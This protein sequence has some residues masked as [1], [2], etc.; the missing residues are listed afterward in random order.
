MNKNESLPLKDLSGTK[1]APG[2]NNLTANTGNPGDSFFRQT[3][4]NLLEGCQILGF[5]WKYIYLNKSAEVHNRRPNAE[6]LGRKYTDMWPGIESSKVFSEIKRCLDDRE[7]IRM[8]NK[9]VYPDQKEGWFNL[10]LQPVPEGALILSYD[11]TRRKT[12]EMQVVRMKR[13]YATLSQVN[14]TLV[15]VTD[16]GDLYQSICDIAVQYGEFSLAWIGLLNEETGDIIPVA[17]KGLDPKNWKFPIANILTGPHKDSLTATAIRQSRVITSENIQTDKRASNLHEKI[18]GYPYHSSAS[19]PFRL[20]GKTIGVVVL[21]S[22]EAGL[23]NSPDEVSLLEEMG[24]DISFALDSIENEREKRAT[25]LIMQQWADAFENCTHGIAIGNSATNQVVSCN[26][27]FAHLLGYTKEEIADNSI[28]NL[29]CPADHAR[30]RKFIHQADASGH[31]QFESDKIRKDGSIIPVQMDIA[32]IKDPRGKVL[33]HIITQQDITN[34][35]Q[36]E[37]ALRENEEKYR[38]LAENISDVIWI[39][40]AETFR[41]RF[42]SQSVEKLLGF[43]CQEVLEQTMNETMTPD[44]AQ[45]VVDIMPVRIDEMKRGILKA[46]TDEI[47]H[48]CKDGSTVWTETTTHFFVNQD[49]G[50]IEVFGSSRNI[51]KR[52]QAEMALRE[53]E[54]LFATVFHSSPIPVSITD[55][56]TEAWL[57]VNEAFL[58]ITGYA[59]EEIIGHT[60]KEINLWKNPADRQ[61]MKD[62]LLRQGRVVNFEVAINKKNGETGTMLIS[63]ELVVLA[64]R[65]YLLIMGNEITSRKKAEEEIRRLNTELE[66]RIAKRTAQLQAA[67][68]ELESFSYSISHDLRA[69]LR[70]IHGFTQIL[71]DDYGPLLDDEGKRVCSIIQE[72]SLK[73]GTLIDDLLAFSR[74]S[75]SDMQLSFINMKSMVNSVFEEITNPALRSRID[76]QIKDIC[77]AQGDPVM[78]RQVWFNLLQNAIKYSSTRE[79]A[80]ISISCI[81]ENGFCIY[82]VTD[83]GVGFD[84]KFLDKLFG[85]FQRLHSAKEFEGTGVGLAIVQRIIHR[86]GGEVWATGELDKGATFSISLPIISNV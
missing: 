20:R 51:T 64:G 35:K 60:F 16:P 8:E 6:L 59:R 46:F 14:Q 32:S 53:S 29:Y 47:E 40:D 50:H 3:L 23:F 57:K 66:E 78:I 86:H 34:R 39:L 25:E 55:I 33:Y 54:A 36:S 52:R 30:I 72:N 27:A 5:D 85:V 69:P 76:L 18:R 75:R 45:Y 15:R 77:D 41:F 84:M 44:S 43:T 13:L 79:K 42:V 22:S 38:L 19:A 28:M 83:N 61:V 65:P 58:T 48:I 26:H 49:S 67:N 11:I 17:A 73:M 70:G 56:S 80:V 21:I 37:T 2:Q 74:F 24:L 62:L 9:F 68:Q 71:L 81:K 4:D 63:G 12:A 82:T 1:P 31:I 7:L 10:S